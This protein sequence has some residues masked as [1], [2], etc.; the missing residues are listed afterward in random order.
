MASFRF[1]SECNNLLYPREERSMRR[2][3]FGCRHCSHE[4]EAE[5]TQVYEHVVSAV[6]R[7]M[8]VEGTDLLVD[9]TVPQKRKMCPNCNA[10]RD[11]IFY[12]SR[13]K[14]REVTMKLTYICT[15][16]RQA[17]ADPDKPKTAG[18]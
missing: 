14:A 2:L 11:A 1:C 12:P 7:E 9:P 17:F 10:M 6:A 16:C 3:M 15:V 18:A 13:S 8:K 4:E 5:H